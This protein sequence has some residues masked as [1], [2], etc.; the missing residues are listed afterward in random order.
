[1]TIA[2][3]GPEKF[4][5]QDLVCVDLALNAMGSGPVTMIPEQAGHE[6]ATLS[7]PATE[8]TPA[9]TIEVQ[10]KGASGIVDITALAEHLLHYPDRAAQGSLL[11]RLMG[12]E[13]RVGL[14][15]MSGRCDDILVPLLL[16]RAPQALAI[17]RAVPTALAETLRAAV[18]AIGNKS[19]AKSATKLRRNRS[20]DAKT[21]AA[22]PLSDYEHALSH[23]AIVERETAETVEVRLHSSLQRLRFD[24]LSIR[25]ILAR[26]TDL[27]GTAKRDQIDVISAMRHELERLA[28]QAVN[29]A[30]YLD[31]GIEVR[32]LKLL[33]YQRVLLLSGPPRAGKSWTSRHIG[34]ELQRLGFEVRSSSHIDEAERFLTDPITAER[35]Y[36]LDD[37][38]GAREPSGDASSR[39]GALRGLIER[40]PPNR[41]LIVAQTES[42]LLQTRGARAIGECALGVWSWFAITPLTIERAVAVWRAAAIA[43]NIEQTAIERVTKLIKRDEDLRDPGALAYLA[44]TFDRLPANAGDTEILFQARSDAVDFAR[45]LATA[46]MGYRTMLSA[47]ALG[48][49]P[50]QAAAILELAFIANGGEARPGFAPKDAPIWRLGGTRRSAP[51]YEALPELDDNQAFAIDNLQRRRIISSEERGL[52]FTHPYLRAGAQALLRPDIPS[53]LD[54]VVKQTERALACVDAST[55]LA[56]ARNLRW[57]RAAVESDARSNIFEIARTGISSLFPATRDACFAFLIDMADELSPAQRHDMPEWANRVAIEL[58]DIDVSNG[59][60]FI[61]EQPHIFVAATPLHEIEPYLSALNA[62]EP[63]GLDLALSRRILLTLR[64]HPE[65]MSAAICRRFLRAD[66]AVIRAAAAGV[67]FSLPREGDND[68]VEWLAHDR[69]PSISKAI[70]DTIAKNW[71]KFEVPRR[72]ALTTML[73]TQATSPGCAT[74]LLDRLVLLNRAEHYGNEPPWSLFAD[75][76]PTVIDHLPLSVSFHNGRLNAALDDA[77]KAIQPQSLGPLVEAWAHRIVHRAAHYTL[78]EYELSIGEPLIASLQPESR[79]PLLRD[80][81]GVADTGVRVVT[82]KWLVAAWKGLTPDEHELVSD[83]LAE[84]RSDRH[85]LAATI[86]TCSAPPAPLVE[87][88]SGD[89]RLLSC[90]AET[91]EA[92]LGFEL[93]A[94]CIRMFRGDPQPLWWYGTHHSSNPDWRRI[95]RVIAAS[96]DHP[97]FGEAFV[98]IASLG[99]EGELLALID[100]LREDALMCTFE[101]LLQYKLACNGFWRDK[102]WRRLLERAKDVSLLDPMFEQIDAVA[103]GILEELHDIELWLGKGPYGRRLLG[104]YHRDMVTIHLLNNIDTIVD[105]VENDAAPDPGQ[106]ALMKHAAIN[107]LVEALE[108]EPCRLS[109]TW[110]SLWIMLRENGGDAELEARIESGR[111]AAVKRHQALRESACD[112]TASIHLEGWVYQKA[113]HGE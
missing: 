88:M 97:L 73:Q 2:I 62:N 91:I 32:L 38:L 49:A 9:V 23:L 75:L 81:L 14:F 107:G 40:L 113:N 1:M 16:D 58:R 52:N 47:A 30:N 101:L 25:G 93:F 79:L 66:E 89:A 99:E 65:A 27:L 59:I 31:R 95:V 39:L 100:A 4:A 34:G 102:S 53:D 18:K 78:D 70:L 72:T 11:E 56:A 74:V 13:D 61:T 37:P 60:G 5:F 19:L 10:V 94:A 12:T 63:L 24:T 105:S 64:Q 80:L 110:N 17:G 54:W 48:T 67:W 22:R 86:L 50:G 26:L 33:E 21:L 106:I 92:E 103:D 29:P 90:S 42:V 7:W 71:K 35:L 44:Q 76:M 108:N 111:M 28:P 55:S 46:S 36:I 84:G 45:S 51:A 69:A 83:A 85:W 82:M 104:L 20:N 15:V 112:V 3:V 87:Q 98:E 8:E 57:L 43:Q 96:P 77:F 68:I 6:D 41:R 109:G